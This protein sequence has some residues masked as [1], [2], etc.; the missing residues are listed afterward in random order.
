M[1]ED[2][3]Q[4]AKLRVMLIDGREGRSDELTRGLEKAGCLVVRRSKPGSDLERAVAESAP[5]VIIIDL[6]SPDRDTLEG[7]CRLGADQPR[8]IVMFMDETDRDSIR[9]AVHAG[10]AAYVVKGSAP[11]RVKPVLDV[12][13]ARFQEHQALKAELR[14]VKSTLDQRKTVE[15]AKG[16]LMEKRSLSE[17]DAYST[18]RKMAM[19][20]S[21]KLH[22]VARRIIDMAD[23]L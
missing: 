4:E 10:V 12:A 14:E 18:L 13:I 11:D 17:N 20:R 16:L 22:E 5:E 3:P 1:L 15:K 23:L 7:M 8:P 19:Q 9:S 2:E 21:V 6:E